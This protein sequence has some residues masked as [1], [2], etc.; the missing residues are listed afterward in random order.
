MKLI[1][2]NITQKT[3]IQMPMLML[4]FQYWM[5]MP[6]AVNSRAHVIAP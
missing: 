5:I 6:A 3:A 1:A 4:L 2:V